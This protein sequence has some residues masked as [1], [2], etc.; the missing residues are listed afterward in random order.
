[1]SASLARSRV[2]AGWLLLPLG[3]AAA[4]FW[5]NSREPGLGD[6]SRPPTGAD[7]E[8]LRDVLGGEWTGAGGVVSFWLAPS[9]ADAERQAFHAQALRKR[10]GL[11][12]GEPWRLRLEWTAGTPNGPVGGVNSGARIDASKLWIESEG[13]ARLSPLSIASD[14]D[15]LATLLAPPAQ[16]LAPGLGVD[17]T[18]WGVAPRG[19]VALRGLGSADEP[20]SGEGVV[21]RPRPLRVAELAGPMARLDL[22]TPASGKKREVP[23]SAAEPEDGDGAHD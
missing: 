18:L 13:G 20:G 3:F 14:M 10:Y 12:N 4:L 9:Q 19:E 23:S 21:L 22:P 8:A 2:G 6:P 7:P 1:M 11:G 5:W 17:V 16:P 15:P